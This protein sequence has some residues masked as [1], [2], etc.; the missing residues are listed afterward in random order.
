MRTHYTLKFSRGLC[1]DTHE[2]PREA[3]RPLVAY[4]RRH[5]RLPFMVSANIFMSHW[6]QGGNL[7]NMPDPT[8]PELARLNA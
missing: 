6:K 5:Q 3:L 1:T 4:M 2:V 8:K 7:M